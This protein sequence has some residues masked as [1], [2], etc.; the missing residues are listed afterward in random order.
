[1]RENRT[2]GNPAQTPP[3]EKNENSVAGSCTNLKF[4]DENCFSDS[5][6]ET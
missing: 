4:E 5:F 1:M 6:F 2:L 3:F